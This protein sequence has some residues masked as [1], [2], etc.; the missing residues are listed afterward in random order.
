MK[1]LRMV[2]F[3]GININGDLV[4]AFALPLAADYGLH[5][6]F[7]GISIFLFRGSPFLLGAWLVS[8]EGSG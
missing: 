3:R 7:L 1:Q 5:F 4:A 2:L 8:V 6:S